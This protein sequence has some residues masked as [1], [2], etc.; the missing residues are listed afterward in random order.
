M[1][2]IKLIP[3]IKFKRIIKSFKTQTNNFNMEH[4][5]NALYSLTLL[6]MERELTEEEKYFYMYAYDILNENNF[7]IDFAVVF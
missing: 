2:H 4:L 1:F 7:E 6:E 5:Y 3:T